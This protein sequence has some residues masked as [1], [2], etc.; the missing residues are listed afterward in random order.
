MTYKG[1]RVQAGKTRS[2]SAK[3]RKAF[4]EKVDQLAEE[5]LRPFASD[6]PSVLFSKDFGSDENRARMLRLYVDYPQLLKAHRAEDPTEFLDGEKPGARAF[7][8]MEL[9]GICESILDRE[10]SKL[11][12]SRLAA[13]EGVIELWKEIYGDEEFVRRLTG[14]WGVR[15]QSPEE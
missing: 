9:L 4:E 15:P 10:G 14:G 2:R 6:L 11:D 3:K 8:S 5:H 12:P 13:F 1:D 7:M